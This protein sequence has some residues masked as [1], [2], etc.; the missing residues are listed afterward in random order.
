VDARLARRGSVASPRSPADIG[1]DVDAL[2]QCVHASSGLPRRDALRELGNRG[3]LRLMDLAAD[4]TL[5]NAAGWTPGL[6]PALERLGSRAVETARRWVDSDDVTLA[7]LGI[8]VLSTHGQVQDGPVLLTAVAQA[9]NDGAWCAVE[10]PARGL[11][12][13]GYRAATEVLRHVWDVTIHS[14]SRDAL[15]DGLAGCAP[16]IATQLAITEASDDCEPTVQR[17]AGTLT[18][19]SR[20]ATP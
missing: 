20:H 11:G 13:I 15:L 14:T 17:N 18:P 2:L 1:G 9:V 4:R 12:R 16:D 8:G 6:A 7:E 5:R 19:H 10:S 3:D